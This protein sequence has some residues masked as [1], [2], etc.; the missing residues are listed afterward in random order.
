MKF[1]VYDNVGGVYVIVIG[2]IYVCDCSVESCI[3]LFMDRNFLC[4]CLL[5]SHE[6]LNLIYVGFKDQP[7]GSK[8]GGSHTY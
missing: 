4:Y 7:Q 3:I 1:F 8:V 2:V 6:S 5:S